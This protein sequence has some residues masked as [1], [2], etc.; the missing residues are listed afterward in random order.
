MIERTFQPQLGLPAA[1][2]YVIHADEDD[3]VK[4]DHSPPAGAHS[5]IGIG[6]IFKARMLA[7]LKIIDYF[8]QIL[9]HLR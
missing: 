8:G 3:V 7:L 1:Q 4:R 6:I 9:A 5:P 2:G